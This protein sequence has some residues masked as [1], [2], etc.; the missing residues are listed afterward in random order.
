MID[1]INGA[2]H[3]TTFTFDAMNRLTGITYPDNT[4][5]SFGY[6]T[7][8]R[9]T[10]ATHLLPWTRAALILSHKGNLDH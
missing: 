2:A 7:R 9:R 8:G 4:T 3:R 6:D 10:S 1:P 5:A